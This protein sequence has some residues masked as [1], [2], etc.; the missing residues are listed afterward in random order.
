MS[1]I[2]GFLDYTAET[3]PDLCTIQTIGNSVQGKPIKVL[4]ISNGNRS[5]KAVWIDGGIHAR[6]WITS[7]VVT[8]IINHVVLN[9]ENEPQYMQN[10]DW[11][12]APLLNP[13]GYE[14]SHTVDRLWRKNRARSG[15]CAGTDLNRNFG[16]RWGGQGSSKNPCT[17]TYG[18]S[19]PF[20]EPE[21]RAVQQFITGNPAKWRAYISFHSYGQYILYPWGYSKAV[22]PDYKDLEMVAK[23]AAAAIRNVGG[24]SYTTGPA[25]NTLY[26]AAGGSDD[27]A[28]GVVKMKYAYTF[29]LR[30]NGR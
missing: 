2:H 4:K 6:E 13:D 1:D 29:E 7:A 15:Q 11:F 21:T 24:P 22:P 25:G 28:K 30:D 26:P 3:Y 10:V 20:S 12:I 14:Y 19:G 8:Y 16:Y 17:E 27:W 23:Q 9:F 18:G 5:N